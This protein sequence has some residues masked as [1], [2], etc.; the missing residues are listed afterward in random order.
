[1]GMGNFEG[2]G[3]PRHAQQHSV[4]N[5]AKIAEP[6][7]TPYALWTQVGSRKHVLDGVQ[8]PYTKGQLLGGKDMPVTLCRELCKNG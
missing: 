6:I 1:M 4:V 3:M 8:I 7:E 5:C 2:K